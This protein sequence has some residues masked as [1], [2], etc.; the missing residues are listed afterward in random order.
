LST[1]PRAFTG[2]LSVSGF[3]LERR[4]WQLNSSIAV[5]KD[6][7]TLLPV[8]TDL[9]KVLRI[10]IINQPLLKQLITRLD[11]TLL[12]L[13]SASI[14]LIEYNERN[15]TF[16]LAWLL[17][18]VLFLFFTLVLVYSFI[19]SYKTRL[20]N[21]QF[22]KFSPFI[23]GIL[24]VP[25]LFIVSDYLRNGG[26]KSVVLKARYEGRYTGINL[27]LYK[28]NTFQLLNSGPFGGK[29]TRGTY[30]F[31]QD[32]LYMEK[33]T[34][35]KIYP[36]NTF[37]LRITG[38]KEKYFEPIMKDSLVHLSLYVAKDRLTNK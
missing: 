4:Y 23:L 30:K 14:I 6:M 15:S 9:L 26:L 24:L 31:V 2:H 11:T 33:D 27:T 13:L 18:L 37:V 29:Y 36:T 35:T 5:L 8:K 12:I 17:M 19:K 38:N 22:L 32:T 21:Q 16:F 1:S 28:D 25:V 34:L 7:A 20:I 3:L 10:E